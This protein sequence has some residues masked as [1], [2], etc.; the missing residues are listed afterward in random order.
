PAALGA[1]LLELGLHGARR[2]LGGRLVPLQAIELSLQVTVLLREA[3]IAARPGLTRRAT[4]LPAEFV[5][6][7]DEARQLTLDLVQERVDLIF[8]VAPLADRG[9]LKGDVVDV[10]RGQRHRGLLGSNAGAAQ[11]LIKPDPTG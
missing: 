9:L 10:G 4:G 2:L 8:V 5:V 6:V 11:V 7:L 1:Q 3:G